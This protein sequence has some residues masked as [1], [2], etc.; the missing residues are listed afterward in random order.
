[1]VIIVVV[2]VIIMVVQSGTIIR[3]I[4]IGVTIRND[5]TTLLIILG[6][7]LCSRIR[8]RGGG[9]VAILVA[10]ILLI[11]TLCFCLVGNTSVSWL[12]STSGC[13]FSGRESSIV[14]ITFCVVGGVLI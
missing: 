4:E 13:F 1:M 11:P 9:M 10:T 7:I 2:V 14:I 8:I 6:G 12:S 5:I 3:G